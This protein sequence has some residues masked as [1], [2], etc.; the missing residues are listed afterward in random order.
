MQ[1]YKTKFYTN[2]LLFFH[3]YLFIERKYK[4]GVCQITQNMDEI[5]LIFHLKFFKSKLKFHFN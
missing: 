5:P 4:N 2:I 1:K 3:I